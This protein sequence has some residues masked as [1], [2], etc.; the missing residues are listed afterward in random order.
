MAMLSITSKFPSSKDELQLGNIDF[1]RLNM[2]I[3]QL[4]QET[5]H[6]YLLLRCINLEKTPEENNHY[7]KLL[8]KLESVLNYVWEQ[9]HTGQWKYVDPTWRQ[10]YSY[11]SLFKAFVHLKLSDENTPSVSDLTNAIKACDMGLIMGEPILNSLLSNIANS[12]N[13]RLWNL[14][15][16]EF[17]LKENVTEGKN[18]QP[19]PKL[20]QSKLVETIHLPSIE[21]FVSEIMN[22][23]PVVITGKKLDINR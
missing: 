4:F 15:K 7:K 3:A 13:E 23:K 8:C 20:N 19:W 17:S 10:L 18:M 12:L 2:S 22:K 21:T 11:V 14:S 9:L 16:A 6:D 5:V 1:N